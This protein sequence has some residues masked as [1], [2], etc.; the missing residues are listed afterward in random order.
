MVFHLWVSTSLGSYVRYPAYQLFTLQFMTVAKL[1]FWNRK[2]NNFLVGESSL[3]AF[4]LGK[5]SWGAYLRTKED[6][7][8]RFSQRRV[9]QSLPICYRI[10]WHTPPSVLNFTPQGLGFSPLPRDILVAASLFSI[11]E[12]AFSLSLFL[13][14]SPSAW[15]HSAP[16]VWSV[17]LPE[18]CPK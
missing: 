3:L 13:P 15:L 16:P 17:N 1:Q 11:C 6:L 4:R 12:H 5:N 18:R 2:E 8:S 14:L 7:A 9:P 10:C